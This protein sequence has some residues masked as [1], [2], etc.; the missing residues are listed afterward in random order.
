MNVKPKL[1]IL[2]FGRKRTGVTDSLSLY[3]RVSIDGFKE[4]ISCG[5]KVRPEH[6]NITLVA[7]PF[8]QFL[9]VD[10]NFCRW[11]LSDS[12]SRW[13]PLP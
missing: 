12:A 8:I 7:P 3:I 13:I 5:I 1:S 2:V 4:E 9:F 10:S 11:L 6:W